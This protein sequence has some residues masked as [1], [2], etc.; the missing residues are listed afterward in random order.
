VSDQKPTDLE[1]DPRFPSGPWTGFFLQKAVPGRHLMELRLQFHAGTVTGEGRDWVGDFTIRG[2]YTID[3]GR[4]HWQKRYVA[5]HDVYY[6]GYAEEKGI[7]GTWEIPT[8][9]LP[10]FRTGGF[11]IWPEGMSDPTQPTLREAADVP[12]AVEEMQ[13]AFAPAEGNNGWPTLLESPL[14][15]TPLDEPD[16]PSLR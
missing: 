9:V 1:T 13:E 2:R 10:G 15:V 16:E 7:W 12:V 4:V 3:N 8:E 5:K 14:I 11:H 6:R